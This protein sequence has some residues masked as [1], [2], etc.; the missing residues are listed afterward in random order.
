MVHPRDRLKLHRIVFQLYE[1]IE[2]A[3][4]MSIDPVYRTKSFILTL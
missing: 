3:A 2:S 4:N 1:G